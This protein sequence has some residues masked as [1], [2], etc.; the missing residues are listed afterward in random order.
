VRTFAFLSK[1]VIVISAFVAS[2]QAQ[3][4]VA[5]VI[6]V[7]A[8]VFTASDSH[9]HAE[10]VAIKGER[11]LAV[12]TNQKIKSLAGPKTKRIDASGRLVIPGIMDTH[13]HYSGVG[14]PTV[15]NI[16]FGEWAPTCAHVLE[17]V[18]QKVRDVPT[19]NLLFGFMGPEAFFDSECTPA[20][21]DRIAP[22][23]PVFLAGGTVHSG[24]LNQAAVKWFGIDTSAPPP[25]A[26]WYGKDMKSKHWD[27]VVQDS[28][29]MALPCEDRHGWISR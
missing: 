29:M 10:A 5:D 15:T 26:G 18:A 9:P 7:N 28:A 11:I 20:E 13:N 8:K 17:I 22:Q 16:D 24:M 2:A 27:G 23:A 4:G 19:G 21:L 3:D 14:L 25:L 6:L 1:V 12:G